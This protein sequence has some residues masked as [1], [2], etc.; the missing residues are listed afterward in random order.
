MH[1][2]LATADTR[3]QCCRTKLKHRDATQKSDHR[4]IPVDR[5]TVRRTSEPNNL[6]GSNY[7]PK[8]KKDYDRAFKLFGIRSKCVYVRTLMRAHT[9]PTHTHHTRSCL[10]QM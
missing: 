3:E 10:L 1:V 9:H 2:T 7:L 5:F 8:K 4:T 6:A